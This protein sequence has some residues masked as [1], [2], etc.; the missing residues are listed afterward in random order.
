MI[1]RVPSDHRLRHPRGLARAGRWLLLGG[2]VSALGSFA[3]AEGLRVAGSWTGKIQPDPRLPVIPWEL[4]VAAHLGDATG[5]TRLELRAELPG[6]NV[7]AKVE[8]IGAD[9]PMRWTV[10]RQT[11]AS[12]PWREIAVRF[13]PALAEWT[14][15]GAVELEGAGTWS[16][17]AG[18]TGAFHVVWRPGRVENA[19]SALVVRQP[20]LRATVGL[21][22]S[23]VASIDVELNWASVDV[24]MIHLGAGALTAHQT[25]AGRWQVGEV[26]APLWQ[27]RVILAPFE[28]DPAHPVINGHVSLAAVAAAE[29]VPFLPDALSSASGRV[30][31]ELTF[32]WDE[33]KGFAPKSG[34]FAILE[35]DKP[36]VRLAAS[37]GLL[38]A[39]VPAK[40]ETMPQW[41]GPIA[42]WMA[43]ENPARDELIEIE[44]GRRT[45]QVERMEARL[46][47]GAVAGETKVQARLV[48]RPQDATAVELVDFTVNVTGPWED[49]IRVSAEDGVKI[50]ATF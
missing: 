34:Q 43:V 22:D 19:S 18:A 9:A 13:L 2:L 10:P 6:G 8:Q 46:V 30:S 29:L 4:T 3:A 17:A 28:V 11:L 45:L 40:I 48:A 27:G 32:A 1:A 38:S 5:A 39:K 26:S 37:P 42:K 49:L 12:E 50:K 35:D 47:P 21:A 31:G 36:K 14:F 16:D 15:D 7:R 44:M 20:V 25:A 41:L 23:T 33:S 24:N